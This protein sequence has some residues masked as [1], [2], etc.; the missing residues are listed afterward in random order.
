[1]QRRQDALDRIPVEGEFCQGTN[2]Y[3]L[4]YIR[5][6]TQKTSEA[7]INSIFLVMNLMDLLRMCFYNF[8]DFVQ[9]AAK[10]LFESITAG[11]MNLVT[12]KPMR[13]ATAP[14]MN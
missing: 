1:M 7:W 10:G 11:I 4:N 13:G 3:R 6:K 2:G 5:G 12:E 14:L 9:G 8:F